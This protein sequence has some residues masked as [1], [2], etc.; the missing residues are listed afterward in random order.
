MES[1]QPIREYLTW[2]G[3][4]DAADLESAL[5]LAEYGPIQRDSAANLFV[6]S[7]K[8]LPVSP[9][10]EQDVALLKLLLGDSADLIHRP[11]SLGQGAL[12]AHLCYVEPMVKKE[13]ISQVLDSLLVRLRNDP[14]P[15]DPEQLERFLREQGIT[16]S[17]ARPLEFLADL[18]S[19]VL[20]GNSLLL[21]QGLFVG[22]ELPTQGWSHRTPEE[23]SSEPVVRGPKEG[24]VET[25]TLNLALVRIRLADPRLR[26]ESHKIGTRTNTLVFM[27]YVSGLAL[28]EI[29]NEV[30]ERISRI[31]IDGILETGALKELIEDTPFTPFPLLR[32]TER[33]DAVAAD[34]L[35]GK[36]ALI[37]NGTPHVLVAP[38]TFWANLQSPEDY[39]ERWWVSSFVR[40]LRYFFLFIALY[41]PA[42]YVA[43]TTF[44]HELV[45]TNLMLSLIS[46]REGVPFPALLEAL[47]MEI[48]FEALREAGVR[49]PK[50]V[51]QA[52]SIVGGFVVGDAAVRA[53]LV[54]PILVVV[55]SL[56]GIASFLIPNFSAALAFRLLRFPMA[57]LG[58]LFGFYGI[59]VGTLIL[60][61]HL[62]SIRSFGVP[63]SAPVMPFTAQD[64]KDLM[65][66]APWWAMTRRP[67]YM[68]TPN[69]KRQKPGQRPSPAKQEE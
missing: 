63:Y 65:I 13:T 20:V 26:V 41:G 52:V 49:L 15:T 46:S 11:L 55:I 47:A 3:G 60:L 37:M 9:T 8:R 32:A 43:I 31:E 5:V 44:H 34:L 57:I 51:G 21:V 6:E 28:P 54:S 12:P 62:A 24:F 39:Y 38:H 23:P 10:L 69:R 58:G 19:T 17:A 42:I 53:G 50:P 4:P 7:S 45:P 29:V 67:R 27:L 2:W 61:A 48:S 1:L 14:F 18:T 64:L 40:L 22:I 59:I 33:P 30:R 66:R 35:E 25:A 36:V 56:T 16:A 68:P